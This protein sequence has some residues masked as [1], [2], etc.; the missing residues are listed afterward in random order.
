MDHIGLTSIVREL[1]LMPAAYNAILHFFRAESWHN[2]TVRC[3]WL[4]VLAKLPILY[5]LDGRPVM[6]GDGVKESKEGRH[7]PGVKKLHQESENS[8]KGEHIFGHMFGGVGLLIG[9]LG[10]K[11]YCVLTSLTLHDGLIAIHE[12]DQDESYK[13]ESHVV[14]TIK[15]AGKAAGI[16]GSAIL[17]LDRLY[18]TV[19]MLKA[20][21]VEPLLQVVT[22]AK[23][24]AAAFLDPKPKTGRGTKRK[25]GEKVR[26]SEFFQT[27]AEE[28]VTEAAYMYG[29]VQAVSYYCID[30]LWG[31]AWY[32]KLRFV[33]VILDG[34]ESIL[35]STDLTLTPVQ[36]IELYCCRFKIECSFR[37]LKQ[38]IA[39]FNYRFWSKFMPRLNRYKSNDENQENLRT[40]TD[41][42]AQAKIEST[43][44]AIEGHVLLSHIALGLL[45][46]ISV[47][48]A[49]FFSNTTLR[50]MR[51]KSNTIPSEST[52]ADYMR[53]NIN[54]LFRFFPDLAITAIINDRQIGSDDWHEGD[55]AA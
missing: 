19:P 27:K 42:N 12:W 35:V 22:K 48:F 5:R 50:F 41:E 54:R 46:I 23:S 45:Q 14:K 51:T 37:E 31:K 9:N 34:K 17:L 25:K 10:Q 11:L 21:A 28:F 3:A 13:E 52:V 32:Q 53:K 7:M 18:L 55:L 43:V 36:I 15:D 38:V 16:L 33:L 26:V 1:C 29:K 24:N 44:R 49:D 47:M 4:R 2:I 30:L 39:G 40:V 8:A 6:V 20:L